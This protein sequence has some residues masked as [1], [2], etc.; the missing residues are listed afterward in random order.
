MLMPLP[1]ARA[2]YRCGIVTVSST[3]H[4]G[5]DQSSAIVRETLSV[6]GHV[7]TRQ[8]WLFDDLSN[9]RDLLR[10]W[11]DSGDLDVIVA[12]GGTGPSP[13]DV[14]PEALAPLVSK[15]MPGFGET[16]RQLAYQEIG[17][18]ALESRACAA[19]CQHTVV[20]MLPGAHQA[21]ALAVKHLI[22]P[23]LDTLE[24][25]GPARATMAPPSPVFEARALPR[26]GWSRH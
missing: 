4:G 17:I 14:T 22:V 13:T 25:T 5:S 10:E 26:V 8:R 3:H 6:A 7:V 16:F 11:I 9:I 1:S 2:G 18:R 23:Q 19:V 20:Y 21:V 12:I 24:W 15:T